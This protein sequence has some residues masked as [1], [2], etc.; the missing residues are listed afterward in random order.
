MKTSIIAFALT[1]FFCTTASAGQLPGAA[2]LPPPVPALPPSSLMAPPSL[3]VEFSDGI[4]LNQFARTIL[5]DYLKVPFVFSSEFLASEA[6]VGFNAKSL[7]KL[8]TEK[9]LSDVLAEQGFSLDK[10][11]GY[12]RIFKQKPEDKLDTRQ[13]FVYQLKHRSAQY[14]LAQVSP[15]LASAS[16]VSATASTSDKPESG[17]T[18]PTASRS[19]SAEDV[20]II[21]ASASDIATLK[22][23]LPE[24][25]TPVPRILV[26]A[27]VIQTAKSE[28]EGFSLS[29]V[30][31]LISS[32][33][34][35]NIGSAVQA[36]P[37]TLTFNTGDFSAVA[38]VL[39]GAGNMRV[40]T[41]PSI[42]AESGKTA[43]LQ[44]GNS[45]PTLGAITQSNGT[46]S[47]SVD[48]KET[49]V[50]LSVAPRVL[51]DAIVVD[52]KQE[53]SDAVSTETGVKNSPTIT[54]NSLS[55]VLNLKSND[56][57]I[58]GGLSTSKQSTTTD[59]LPFFNWLKL[60]KLNSASDSDIVIVLQVSKLD[61]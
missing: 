55:T 50:M 28:K 24:I 9:L 11:D 25:D 40:L 13:V 20:F 1:A 58:L 53:I 51:S 3:S 8:A 36:L 26:R 31:S 48:Y 5:Q 46:T 23:V 16:S 19:S 56:W 21:K 22:K 47:Q 59:T 32:K 54:K 38:G 14:V 29:A 57:V 45:V 42:I 18:L 39:A 60:G 7:K 44:V 6:Q 15:L 33:L 12:Y 4:R 2:T 17:S 35:V 10:K 43:T 41:S 34:S 49:G 52:V 61:A 37:N 27:F 30:A